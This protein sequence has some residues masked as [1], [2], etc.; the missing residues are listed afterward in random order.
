MLQIIHRT[1]IPDEDLLK[2]KAVKS[3]RWGN[4]LVTCRTCGAEEV[5]MDLH[6]WVCKSHS[7]ETAPKKTD[8]PIQAEKKQKISRK[9]VYKFPKKSDPIVK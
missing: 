5:T 4:F 3:L 1:L 9:I 8:K 2:F 6:K 7:D